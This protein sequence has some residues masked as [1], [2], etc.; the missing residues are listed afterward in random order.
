M[1][2]KNM[3][4]LVIIAPNQG[5]EIIGCYPY[6][7]DNEYSSCII[8]P[9][10]YHN[11]NISL[12]LGKKSELNVKSQMFLQSVPTNFF[13][14]KGEFTF[15]YPHPYYSYEYNLRKYGIE[16][17]NFARHGYDVI[18]YATN[19]DTVPFKQVCRESLNKKKLLHE[20]YPDLRLKYS[21]KPDCFNYNAFDKWIFKF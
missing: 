17:E 19:M 14:T 6:L 1:L 2:S 15:L 20:I 5:D 11:K 7:I 10:V 16:G 8:Y 4:N 12:A 21:K 9:D 3:K 18:F 13:R